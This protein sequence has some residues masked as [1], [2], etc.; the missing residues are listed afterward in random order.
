M[1]ER[2]KIAMILAE[3]LGAAILT[4]VV[5]A[6][7]KTNIGIP[8]FVSLI[9]GLALAAGTMVFGAVSG[10]HFNPAITISLWTARQIK[11]LPALAYIAAQM[12]GGLVAYL[13]YSYIVNATL[14]QGGGEYKSRVLVAEAAGAFVFALGWAATVYHKLD[15]SKS[16]F[17]VGAAFVVGVTVASLGSAGYLN[18]AVALGAQSWVWGTYVL[19]P[20]LGAIIGFN[21]YALL[22]APAES[23][24]S[25]SNSGGSKK[26]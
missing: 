6:V 13:L 7:S 15:R 11:T 22:F 9:A 19:G 8:Y 5:L 14:Q 3:F 18:P 20:I 10:A 23:L 24:V 25:R 16:A 1:L 26:K 4:A 21:V 2:K 17:V 12:L